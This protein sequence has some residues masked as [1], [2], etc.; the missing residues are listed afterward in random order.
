MGIRHRFA[1]LEKKL[2]LAWDSRVRTYEGGGRD[3]VTRDELGRVVAIVGQ[4][5]HG[6]WGNDPRT[7][8]GGLLA[9][10]KDLETLAAL[11]PDLWEV[12]Q[13]KSTERPPEQLWHARNKF[14]GKESYG[15]TEEEAKACAS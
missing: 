14:T 6:R 11:I 5:D 13:Y 3:F 9:S 8:Y 1:K 4:S 10:Q 2:G 15:A 7:V 12:R